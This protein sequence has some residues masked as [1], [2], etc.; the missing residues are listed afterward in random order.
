MAEVM[1]P[2]GQVGRSARGSSCPKLDIWAVLVSLVLNPWVMAYPTLI[3]LGIWAR[4]DPFQPDS[5]SL[6]G[7]A[8]CL[9]MWSVFSCS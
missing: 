3:C 5:H 2:M 8:F 7:C 9:D 4:F 1:G 6:V